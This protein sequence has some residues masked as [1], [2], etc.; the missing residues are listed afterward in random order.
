M[1]QSLRQIK[2]KIRNIENVRKVTHAMEMIATAK[3]KTIENQVLISRQY[4]AKVEELL[5]NLLAHRGALNLPLLNRRDNQDKIILCVIASDTGLCST[6]NSDMFCCVEDYIRQEGSKTIE[7]VAVGKKAFNYFKKRNLK[8]RES[9]LEFHGRYSEG[10]ACQI[11]NILIEYFVCG[12][13]DSVVLAYTHFETAS[14][15]KVK[16]EKL[17]P[18]EAREQEMH[19]MLFEPDVQKITEDLIPV[20]VFNKIKTILLESFASEH[21]SRM[22]AMGEATENAR[23]LLEDMILLRNK[24]RQANITNEILE[25]SSTAEALR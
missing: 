24:V 18:I 6:Y 14:R 13:I 1:I 10:I 20:F 16:L 11:L 19:F 17:F 15:H 5:Y 8:I 25:I 9:F 23:G 22:M 3:F 12:D 4:L 7:V 21:A 2:S